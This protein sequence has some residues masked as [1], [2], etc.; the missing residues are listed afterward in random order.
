MNL[1]LVKKKYIDNPN[2][3]SDSFWKSANVISPLQLLRSTF[4][5]E[6]TFSLASN[7]NPST[8]SVTVIAPINFQTKNINGWVIVFFYLRLFFEISSIKM[9]TQ[10][11]RMFLF[12]GSLGTKDY[13]EVI[14]CSKYTFF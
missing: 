4:S 9:G 12:F 6:I 2:A 8:F 11:P 10:A 3:L 1:L 13:R 5:M 14:N 7:W